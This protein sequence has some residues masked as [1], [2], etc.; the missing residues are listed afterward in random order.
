MPDDGYLET[1]LRLCGR[2]TRAAA[3]TVRAGLLS[4][5]GSACGR[6]AASSSHHG[7]SSTLSLMRV[8]RSLRR[9]WLW[10]PVQAR[11]LS[12]L[13]CVGLRN[14]AM[15]TPP[16]LNAPP[17]HGLASA[18]L[19]SLGGQIATSLGRGAGLLPPVTR[20]ES[21]AR[22]RRLRAAGR[23]LQGPA[24]DERPAVGEGEKPAPR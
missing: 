16:T 4:R 15:L 5:C 6:C 9:A 10:R 13:T 14:A 18:G 8:T 12:S 22:Q 1:C 11:A 7:G 2:L 17:M 21:E 23:L 20:E 24:G 3:A 19:A